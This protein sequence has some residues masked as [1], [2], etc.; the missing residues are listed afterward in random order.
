[1]LSS[2]R[3]SGTEVSHPD[4]GCTLKTTFSGDEEERGEQA[5]HIIKCLVIA[6]RLDMKPT[7][8]AAEIRQYFN[9][10]NDCT[11]VKDLRTGEES[12]D[13]NAVMGGSLDPFIKSCLLKLNN[14]LFRPI[15]S[16][17]EKDQKSE[18]KS[19]QRKK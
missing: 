2:L 9:V 11:I 8:D 7:A 3:I 6:D 10:L 12:T 17:E 13:Y 1:M 19:K 15:H 14:Q 16:Q 4:S 18:K 5:M